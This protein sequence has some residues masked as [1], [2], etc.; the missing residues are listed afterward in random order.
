MKNTI[1]ILT[2]TLFTILCSGCDQL[3][4]AE[5]SDFFYVRND[6]ADMPV[7]VCGNKDSDVIVLMLHGGP[8][9][10][11]L[12]YHYM[13]YISDME[14]DFAFAYWEQRAAGSSQGNSDES[15]FT[16]DQYIDDLDTVIEVLEYK[17]DS[18]TIFLCGHSWGGTLGTAYLLDYTYQ[19][20][21][22]GWI[23]LDGGHDLVTGYEL[24]R[25][26]VMDYAN[27]KIDS[28]DDPDGDYSEMIDWYEEN[29]VMT[30]DNVLTHASYVDD[31]HGYIPEGET[32]SMDTT[33]YAFFS[34]A[35]YLQLLMN[36]SYTVSNFDT[37][38]MNFV[39]EMDQIVLPSLILWGESDGIL[40]VDLAQQ[41]Y[42]ALGTAEDDKYITTLPN[43]GHSPVDKDIDLFQETFVEFIN[44][45][46]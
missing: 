17:Y 1:Y 5:D 25:E 11:A 37:T 27:E 26:F 15:D 35:N 45:Y 13:D 6:D 33:T 39:D 21:I 34:P 31:V 36:S 12:A 24:S 41:A 7:W 28:G 8:G 23:E 18:P 2:I 3:Y 43:S 16:L 44:N 38:Q 10:T 19:A 29:T 14:E 32:I 20:K 30:M 9:D 22:T 42:D 40:P 46:R 4:N